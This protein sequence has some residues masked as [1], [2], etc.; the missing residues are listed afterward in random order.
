MK[1]PEEN[2]VPLDDE[3]DY[4]Q[5]VFVEPLSVVLHG[6]SLMPFI[7]NQPVVIIGLGTIGLLALQTVKAFGAKEIHV[8]DIE[9]K[10]LE[11]ANSFGATYSYHPIEDAAPL[12]EICERGIPLVIET[13]GVP[14]SERMA[15]DIASP[16]GNV[17]YIGIPEKEVAFTKENFLKIIR[18][19]LTIKGSWMSYEAPFPGKS[20][21]GAVDLMKQGIIQWEQMINQVVDF[22]N[23]IDRLKQMN[24]SKGVNGKIIIK[25]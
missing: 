15:I 25:I 13:A 8:V 14:E 24:Q 3:V 11:L 6:L 18:K 20:W 9:E 17:L 16:K 5:G 21:Y 23:S 4:V 22:D 10:K 12:D 1:L 19:E 2:I 7:P